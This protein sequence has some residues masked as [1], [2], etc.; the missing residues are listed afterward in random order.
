[1]IIGNRVR[2][3]PFPLRPSRRADDA[4]PAHQHLHGAVADLDPVAEPQLGVNSSRSVGA[5]RVEMDL[6][7]QVGQPDM[8]YRAS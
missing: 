1:M 4:S 5:S 2:L 8:P 6:P 7:D 3:V